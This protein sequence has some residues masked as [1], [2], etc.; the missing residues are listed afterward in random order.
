MAVNFSR[1]LGFLE[2]AEDVNDS[3]A[4]SAFAGRILAWVAHLPSVERLL[5]C[6]SNKPIFTGPVQFSLQMIQERRQSGDAHIHSP[7][8]LLDNFFALHKADPESITD[9]LVLC[10]LV[11]DIAAGGDTT[12]AT[13]SGIVYNMIEHPNVLRRLQEEL[14]VNITQMPISWKAAA[15]LPYLDAVIQESIRYHPGTS[16]TFEPVVPQEGLR[17]PDGRFI[18]PGTVV[19]MHDWVVNRDKTVFGPDV[20][21][22]M[23][24]RWLQAEGEDAAVFSTRFNLMKNTVLSFGAGTRRCVGKNLAMLVMYKFLASLFS[25]FE[26]ELV[27]KEK[28]PKLF[29]TTFV[30]IMDFNVTLKPRVRNEIAGI[31]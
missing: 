21:S 9:G 10:A 3:L 31:E 27:N 16:F 11:T 2:K 12:A 7:P 25:K 15:N 5:P 26:I 1:M 19:G 28:G 23:P 13:M 29:H 6:L 17:L 18:A 22:F 4:E 14:D 24:N 30:Q 20:D 8:D